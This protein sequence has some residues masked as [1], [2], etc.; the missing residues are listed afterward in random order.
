MN[1]DKSERAETQKKKLKSFFYD[2]SLRK[3]VF[4]YSVGIALVFSIAFILYTIG[5][6]PGLYEEYMEKIEIDEAM[7]FH[8]K[9]VRNGTEIKH[10][11]LP[12]SNITG[13]VFSKKEPTFNIM[14][15]FG[16]F[17]VNIQDEDMKNLYMQ[18]ITKVD[19]FKGI[20]REKLKKKNGKDYTDF[21]KIFEIPEEQIDKVTLKFNNLLRIKQNGA[22]S[23]KRMKDNRNATI[24]VQFPGKNLYIIKA[25]YRERGVSYINRLIISDNG[26]SI[27]VTLSSMISRGFNHIAE[28]VG[29]SIPTVLVLIALISY[30]ATGIFSRTI[31]DP[32]ISLQKKTRLISETSSQVSIAM[33]REDEIGVLSRDIENFYIRLKKQYE[34]LMEENEKREIVLRSFSHKLKTPIAASIMIIDAMV[35]NIGD[36]RENPTYLKNLRDRI[37]ETQVSIDRLLRLEYKTQ[38]NMNPISPAD[39]LLSNLKK[40]SGMEKNRKVSWNI[41]GDSIWQTDREILEE[42][43]ENLVSNCFKHSK[44]NF[45]VYALIDDD[46][47]TLTNSP[48]TIPDDVLKNAFEPFVSRISEK[49]SGLGLY[50]ARYNAR[51]LGL[52]LRIE[53]TEDGVRVV[54]ERLKGL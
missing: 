45:N 14:D 11:N 2:M 52:T 18:V 33:D 28:V 30:I 42:I 32:I 44:E 7:T 1:R 21:L 22:N 40:Y 13:I 16:K 6:L 24:D 41:K 4:I 47:I 5:M 54:L 53:N 17:N 9:L 38:L 35:D 29:K 26:D 50:I 34:L 46:K 19:S 31:V 36:F 20:D 8:E 43:L 48:A 49:G 15:S 27:V 23:F 37:L 51:R 12:S 25:T 10:L 39:I 3:K